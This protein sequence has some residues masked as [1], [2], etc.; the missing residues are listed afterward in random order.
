MNKYR[1]IR[2]AFYYP[3]FTLLWACSTP[4]VHDGNQSE[5]L[6][7]IEAQGNSVE[8]YDGLQNTLKF[9]TTLLTN[10]LR[11]YQ[12]EIRSKNFKWTEEQ[13]QSE[14]DKDQQER[15]QAT[16]I[17]I[18][19]YTP[20][21]KHGNLMSNK[22]PWKVFLDTGGSRYQAKFTEQ[23]ETTEE[24]Q[25]FYPYHNRWSTPYIARFLIPITTVEKQPATLT[26]TGLLDSATVTFNP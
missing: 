8:T 20:N 24:I 23:R 19:L 7:A 25:K 16:E 13:K 18:S 26:I 6:A 4:D 1:L 14:K 10:R 22:S 21:R 12:L 11:D 5:Y 2:A 3:L 9:Q 17:F 15:A